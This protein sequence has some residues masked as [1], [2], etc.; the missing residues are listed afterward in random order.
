MT[1]VSPE[2][3]RSWAE[4]SSRRRNHS[5]HLVESG[6]SRAI[7]LVATSNYATHNREILSDQLFMENIRAPKISSTLRFFLGQSILILSI[8]IPETHRLRPIFIPR[9]FPSVP[10]RYLRSLY[11]YVTP[12]RSLL[13]LLIVSS[14]QT[15]YT[16]TCG[17]VSPRCLSGSPTFPISAESHVGSSRRFSVSLS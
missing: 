17:S 9:T 5:C 12:Y 3:P 6:C 1:P 11:S 16:R 15:R 7:A 10:R 14:S 8:P 2:I 4:R 13:L